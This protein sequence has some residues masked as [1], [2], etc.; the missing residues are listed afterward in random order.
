M[1]CP[2]A[3][4]RDAPAVPCRRREQHTHTIH[5]LPPRHRFFCP[6]CAAQSKQRQADNKALWDYLKDMSELAQLEPPAR[7]TAP[8]NGDVHGDTVHANG[9]PPS[10]ESRY[11]MPARCAADAGRGPDG[12]EYCMR[13]PGTDTGTD[14]G[15]ADPIKPDPDLDS[16]SRVIVMGAADGA[17]APALAPVDSTSQPPDFQWN[18]HSTRQLVEAA[19]APTSNR[20]AYLS[21]PSHPIHC[22][23]G[24][25][26]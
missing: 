23:H 17:A 11:S 21:I 2:P 13:R 18:C 24:M 6:R 1:S 15:D 12:C 25:V 26:T 9:H 10:A 14:T 16:G 20:Y 22:M 5:F 19:S 3:T 7:E 8:A 4:P